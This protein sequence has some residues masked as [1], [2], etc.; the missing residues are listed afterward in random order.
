VR[1][2]LD[3]PVAKTLGNDPNPPP[4]PHCLIGARASPDSE[5]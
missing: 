4:P 1:G 3:V 2:Q 5:K